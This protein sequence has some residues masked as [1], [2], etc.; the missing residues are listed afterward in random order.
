MTKTI[1]VVAVMS[2]KLNTVF[3]DNE[4]NNH[5]VSNSDP[6]LSVLLDKIR[7][8]MLRGQSATISLED[9]SLYEEFEKQTNGLVRFFRAAKKAV[10][11]IVETFVPPVPE[12]EPEKP[13][14]EPV[15][16]E[17]A[18]ESVPTIPLTTEP[19]MVA[20]DPVVVPEPVAPPKPRYEDIKHELKPVKNDTPIAHDETLVAVINGVA[21]PGIEGLKPYIQN[22]LRTNSPKA[23]TAFLER[24]A[25]VIDQRG[26][27]IPDLM[28]FLSGGD[29]PLA[30]DGCIIGYK[31]LRRSEA[32]QGF[33]FV[34]CHTGRVHQRVGTKVMVSE[35][36]VDKNRHNEC[37]NG[38]HVARRGYIGSFGGDVCTM[39]K[40]NPEDVIAVPH[41]D[42][43]KVRVSAYH[44]IFLLNDH[45]YNVLRA[46]KPMTSD[47]EAAAMLAKAISGDH[48]GVLEEVWIGGQAGGNLSI[49]NRMEGAQAVAERKKTVINVQTE[50]EKVLA[51]DDAALGISPKELNEKNRE[52]KAKVVVEETKA[53]EIAKRPVE[54]YGNII[55][56]NDVIGAE[57]LLAFKK[58]AKKSWKSMKLPDNAGEVLEGVISGFNKEIVQATEKAIKAEKPK[59]EP[60]KKTPSKVAVDE[61]VNREKIAVVKKPKK[62]EPAKPVSDAPAKEWARY[63]F[64]K[65]NWVNLYNLKK[66]KKVSWERLGF[67]SDEETTINKNKP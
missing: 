44:I 60:K 26:H 15:I 9:Y 17:K 27:S 54:V 39:I 67:T 63:W 11:S 46:N 18:V 62:I 55:K 64:I 36:M 34:D 23:V 43:R 29:L 12:P 51:I 14:A 33:T 8:A 22:A 66:S 57:A 61:K 7:P 38:L 31:I 45:V 2:D 59:A 65:E 19:E 4:G 5:T 42:P 56:N 40:M 41:G 47:P 30:E 3:V 37:S 28:S 13:Y 6:R 35:D 16:T 53:K 52:E 50:I 48:V 1:T 58:K 20:I 24:I 25:R 49:K 10:Q 32:H 21:I